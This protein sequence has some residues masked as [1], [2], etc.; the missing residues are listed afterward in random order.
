MGKRR[1]FH[2]KKIAKAQLILFSRA[3]NPRS[4]SNM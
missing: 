2:R 4:A 1:H 3:R